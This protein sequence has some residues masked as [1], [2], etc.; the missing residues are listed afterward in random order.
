MNLATPARSSTAA[1]ST[2]TLPGM[3]TWTSA[4]DSRHPVL[5]RWPAA[6]GPAVALVS[7]AAG[8]NRQSLAITLPAAAV[9]HLAAAALGRPWTAWP[10]VPGAGLVVVS[11]SIGIAWWAGLA[12]ASAVLVCVGLALRVPR[13]AL[14]AQALA[15]AGFGCAAAIAV[16]VAPWTAWSWPVSRSPAM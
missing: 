7:L 14:L 3:S 15:A 8:G 13:P 6:L 10:A 4:A 2:P 5:R 1:T 16:L 11:E 12:G 9:C